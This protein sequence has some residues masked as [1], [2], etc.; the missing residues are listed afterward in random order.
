MRRQANPS[1]PS[2]PCFEDDLPKDKQ[3]SSRRPLLLIL[4]LVAILSC[5]AF[6]LTPHDSNNNL[7]NLQQQQ[8]QQQKQQ[9]EPPQQP[10]QLEVP[11][12]PDL[13]ALTEEFTAQERTV[14]KMKSEL[15]RRD[16]PE[17]MEADEHGMIETKELQRLSL[18][19]LRAEF[20]P[21]PPDGRRRIVF[22][23]SFPSN[24][25]GPPT[26]TLEIL[27]APD[28]SNPYSVLK[29]LSYAKHWTHGAFHRKAG[30][31]LQ[32]KIA[33]AFSYGGTK[34]DASLAFQEYNPAFPHKKGTLGYAG[35][36]SGPSF[37]ISTQD[38]SKNQ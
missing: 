28:S 10:F 8:Q 16:P 35:R 4:S 21:S 11:A 14:R 38:N 12:A 5:A 13:S 17:W 19:L 26:E 23:L 31:V 25:E 29:F 2:I 30:H 15:K 32:A 36:P 22:H 3:S 7:P 20:G 34:G 9:H 18:A 33:D 37:Y 6:F 27:M 24:I 1:H